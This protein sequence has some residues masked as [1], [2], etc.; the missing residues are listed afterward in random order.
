M[1]R[2]MQ[3]LAASLLALATAAAYAQDLGALLA[4]LLAHKD[5]SG[6]YGAVST[7]VGLIVKYVGTSQSGLVAV[8]AATG[9]LTF[10]SGV[11]GAEVADTSF[12]CPIAGGLGGVIDVSDPAC[13]SFGEVINTI[14][15]NCT[16]CNSSNWRA[17]VV[18]ALFADTSVNTLITLSATAAGRPAG[19]ALLKD[20][21]VALNF[22][23]QFGLRN[24]A[25]DYISQQTD[26]L[27]PNPFF[28]TTVS[29]YN[30]ATTVTTTGASTVS[31]VCATSSYRAGAS[32]AET[33]RT[34]WSQAG[35]AT[36]VEK[37][38]SFAYGLACLPDERMLLRNTCTTTLTA[39]T[40][41]GAAKVAQPAH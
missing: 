23:K 36:T 28:N 26:A 33:S 32:S 12:E 41:Y 21:T 3:V 10:T 20:T 11:L 39:A 6:G 29:L 30:Y 22:T 35:G 16:G 8:D 5:A 27:L 19:L 38:G 18:D 1:K 31:V 9:D 14:N 34:A 40:L 24:D 25:R 13:D 37:T 2:K 4:G 17:V 7:D 15:G